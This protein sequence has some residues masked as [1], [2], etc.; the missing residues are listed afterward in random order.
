MRLTG[1]G[2]TTPSPRRFKV[3]QAP[4]GKQHLVHDIF[5]YVPGRSLSSCSL[6]N[7]GFYAQTQCLCVCLIVS[8]FGFS[9]L[10]TTLLL[11]EAFHRTSTQD[12]PNILSWRRSESQKKH[13]QE[14]GV[15][16]MEEFVDKYATTRGDH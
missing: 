9:G 3:H 13:D 10:A 11:K 4:T 12:D 5:P 14:G 6:A 1:M 15:G 8:F 16:G 2:L 7:S